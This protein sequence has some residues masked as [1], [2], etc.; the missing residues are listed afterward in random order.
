MFQKVKEQ[1]GFPHPWFCN[2]GHESALGLDPI[3]QGCHCLKMGGAEVK[4]MRIGSNPER[5]LKETK[6]IEEHWLYLST[7][8]WNGNRRRNVEKGPQRGTLHKRSN[9]N[10]QIQADAVIALE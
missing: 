4:K 9:I 8:S 10:T 2:H 1:S 6:V 3:E 5:L 7:V